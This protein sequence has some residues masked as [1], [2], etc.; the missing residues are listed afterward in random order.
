MVIFL[1]CKLKLMLHD[2]HIA[3]GDV[4]NSTWEMAISDSLELVRV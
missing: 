3:W 4:D 2:C 1:I